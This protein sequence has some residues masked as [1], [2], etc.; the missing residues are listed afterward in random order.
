MKLYASLVL[1]ALGCQGASGEPVPMTQVFSGIDSYDAIAVRDGVVYAEILGAGVVSCPIAGCQI[2]SSVASSESFVSG[3]LGAPISY[4]AQVADLDGVTGE[5]HVIDGAG[6]HALATNL[7]Y[8]SWVATAG[9]RTFVAED[10]FGYDD[11]PATIDC[12]GCTDEQSKVT[13]WISGFGG[14]TYGML[15]DASN[16]YVLADDAVLGSVQLVAC[17]VLHPCYSEPRV[18][19]DGLDP[20]ITAQQIASDGSAVYVARAKKADVV[21]VDPSGA[22]TRILTTTNATAIAWDAASGSLYFGT[23][24]GNVGRVKND[25]LLPVIFAHSDTAIGAIAVDDTTVYVVTGDNAS[26]VMKTAK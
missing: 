2:P 6:D 15:A 19:L 26:V 20:T 18:V 25:G 12:A 17:S 8:P 13:P 21:R 5:L 22:M 1:V 9:A 23:L 3:A 16:V 7:V 14:G 24:S 10:S 4:A 11:T